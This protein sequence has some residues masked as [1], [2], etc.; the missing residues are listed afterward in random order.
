LKKKILYLFSDTGGGHRSGANALINAVNTIKP[1]AFDQEM[2]DVF[3]EGS[4]FLN[5]FAKLYAHVIKYSPQFWGMLYYF[6]DD[7]KKLERLEKISRPFIL[8]ALAEIIK[9]KKPDIIVSVHPLVNHLTVTAIK[10][11]GRKIPFIVV[12][13]DPVTLHRSWV[14]PDPDLY[15][16]A[17]EDA[18][19]LAVKFGLSEKKILVRGM[20]IDPKFAKG[21]QNK[22]SLRKEDNLA[23][24][25]FTILL[26]GG[27]EGGGGMLK[28]VKEIEKSG[29]DVQLIVIAG[30]NKN[31][32]DQL[33]KNIPKSSIPMKIYG[34]TDQVYR[35]M[36]Q[37]DLIITKAGPGTIAEALAMNLPIIITSWLPGQEEGNVDFVVKN[38]LG[39]VTK[40]PQR[41]V[42]IIKDLKVRDTYQKIQKNIEKARH[43]NAA[44]DI[45][46]DII[47][48]L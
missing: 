26:M 30:R 48:F 46:A 25:K 14:T 28:I 18:K 5:I 10:E 21:P 41:I 15:I 45:A 39:K 6:L 7:E 1:G 20:P 43:P 27:G 42:E 19:R 35:I 16:V 13:M 3:A 9:K 24:D 2:V 38:S 4:S 34:F 12:V 8:K 17:T 22:I 23:L 32:K 31:L 36:S 37:S 44:L 29:L 33:D 40:D 47:K 11:S